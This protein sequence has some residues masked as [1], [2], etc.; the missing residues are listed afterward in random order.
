MGEAKRRAQQGLP[1][2]Q[3]NKTKKMSNKISPL[4]PITKDQ[5]ER[6]FSITKTGA[7]IGVFLLVIFWVTVRFIGPT[8][9]WWTLADTR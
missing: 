3:T 1:P 4:L 8:A 9:G 5:Q 2:K 7:W 6:F